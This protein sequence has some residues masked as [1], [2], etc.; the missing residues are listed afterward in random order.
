MS[1]TLDGQGTPVPVEVKTFQAGKKTVLLFGD[2]EIGLNDFL[3][4][5]F[6]V[7]T[8]TDLDP[9]GD[10]RLKFVGMVDGLMLA[11]GYNGVG[12]RL[13]PR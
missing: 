10:D 5:A 11:E 4:A 2:K 6:Y 3:Q 13:K 9:E 12:T 8:N 7:L 1:L